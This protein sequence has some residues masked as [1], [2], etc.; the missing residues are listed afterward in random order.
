MKLERLIHTVGLNLQRGAFARGAYLKK[1]K[2]FAEMGE[3][4]RFQPRMV[5]LYPELI[6]FHSNIMIGAGV[7]F[8]THDAVHTV[9]NRMDIG[10]FPEMVG[11][12][13][14]MDNVFIGTDSTIMLNVRI[15]KNVIIG[16]SSV[17]TKDCEDNSIYAG[18]PARKIGS[19]DDFVAKRLA[20]DYAT[21]ARNQ[22]ITDKEMEEAWSRF[23]KARNEP[24]L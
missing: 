1:K 17:V 19:F 22:Q 23:E 24:S 10:K 2:V 6:K 14:V 12:I 21:V 15:G 5:P 9:L 13:E 3:W 7:R 4:V 11:C 16:A 20:G 8:V 18:I